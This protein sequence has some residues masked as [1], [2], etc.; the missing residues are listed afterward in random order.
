MSDQ[1]NQTEKTK[2]EDITGYAKQVSKTDEIVDTSRAGQESE[3]QYE[4]DDGS[5]RLIPRNENLNYTVDKITKDFLINYYGDYIDSTLEELMIKNY[6]DENDLKEIN[7]IVANEQVEFMRLFGKK[8]EISDEIRLNFFS[9]KEN[10][11]LKEERMKRDG[12]LFCALA[13]MDFLFDRNNSDFLN[14]SV[15]KTNIKAGKAVRRERLNAREQIE[16]C[17]LVRQGREKGIFDKNDEDVFVKLL[18]KIVEKAAQNRESIWDYVNRNYLE[19]KYTIK[20][21]SKIRKAY[22]V[23]SCLIWFKQLLPDYQYDSHMG[24]GRMHKLNLFFRHILPSIAVQAR[25]NSMDGE[26]LPYPDKTKADKAMRLY[27]YYQV[28]LKRL[29]SLYSGFIE[30]KLKEAP[31]DVEKPF[32]YKS[33][34]EN[35]EGI[36]ANLLGNIKTA[37]KNYLSK[38]FRNDTDLKINE[39]YLKSLVSWTINKSPEAFLPSFLT[40]KICIR[41]MEEK[42]TWNDQPEG[43]KLV[44]RSKKRYAQ[45]SLFNDLLRLFDQLYEPY[46]R[47]TS[48]C[49]KDTFVDNCR[50]I[51]SRPSFG[52]LISSVEE[53]KL[54]KC[55]IEEYH[56]AYEDIPEIGFQLFCYDCLNFNDTLN[57]CIFPRFERIEFKAPY[58][59]IVKTYS[60][61][62]N[63]NRELIRENAIEFFKENQELVKGYEAFRSDIVRYHRWRREWLRDRRAEGADFKLINTKDKNFESCDKNFRLET[64]LIMCANNHAREKL[65]K[66][67]VDKFE[68]D[69]KMFRCLEDIK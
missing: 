5:W 35:V 4:G 64:G 48:G 53:V 58:R 47:K 16:H 21:S 20:I 30:N 31:H 36:D 63:D 28:R 56:A 12:V 8:G 41:E 62:I 69:K 10:V 18:D 14:K 24:F 68:L 50:L 17:Y 33:N 22:I 34:S 60:D 43:K 26:E 1:S 37:L 54:W 3:D 46:Y 38:I 57:D 2:K 40:A 49:K 45:L 15:N 59:W 39:N 66:I 32:V 51:L 6:E 65:Q 9:T 61:I 11:V 55:L 23:S 27:V 42:L 19:K 25:I 13:D 52:I 7:G 67:C 29:K 44:A